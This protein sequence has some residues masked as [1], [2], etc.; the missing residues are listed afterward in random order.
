MEGKLKRSSQL[1]TPRALNSR[2]TSPL[3]LFKVFFP[4]LARSTAAIF[5]K[6]KCLETRRRA[7]MREEN[8]TVVVAKL[9]LRPHELQNSCILNRPLRPNVQSDCD[10][11]EKTPPLTAQRERLGAGPRRPACAPQE[12]LENIG[13]TEKIEGF[14]SPEKSSFRSDCC[15][16]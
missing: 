5:Q 15:F 3:S 7:G 1:N 4:T 8:K 14:Y 10:S 9:E 16:S 11:V 13:I 6:V 2:R 12:I